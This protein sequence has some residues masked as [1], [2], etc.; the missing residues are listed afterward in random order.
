VNVHILNGSCRILGFKKRHEPIVEDIC[1]FIHV[2]TWAMGWLRLVGSLK[3][4]VSFAEY[5]VFYRALLQKR[6]IILRSLLVE[7]TPYGFVTFPSRF[8][9]QLQKTWRTH[10]PSTYI[11]I[12]LY[13]HIYIYTRIYVQTYMN[14]HIL[15]G[16]RH[17]FS[18]N[19]R[20]EPIALRPTNIYYVYTCCYCTQICMYMRMYLHTY[21]Q[22]TYICIYT[23]VCTYICVQYQH[24]YT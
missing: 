7:A 13:V 3:L 16:L 10:S 15:N 6:P 20:H 17:I 5:R 12:Y 24:A 11:Y 18:C 4:S 14:V 23:Y 8:W 22:Y 1:T 9:L 19:K 2:C 21:V